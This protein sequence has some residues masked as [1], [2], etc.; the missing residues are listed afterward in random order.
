MSHDWQICFNVSNVTFADLEI[1]D[2]KI[3]GIGNRGQKCNLIP[4]NV[5]RDALNITDVNN[6]GLNI[7]DVNIDIL[8][9]DPERRFRYRIKEI[10]E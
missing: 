1:F 4:I 6:N 8:V 5:I 2:E 10:K 7:T 3:E 9:K